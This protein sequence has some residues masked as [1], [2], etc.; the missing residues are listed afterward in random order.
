MT[1]IKCVS[2][3]NLSVKKLK[4]NELY[5]EA[6]KCKLGNGKNRTAYVCYLLKHVK[7]IEF[8]CV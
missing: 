8:T 4:Y 2:Y 5:H 7:I 6:V 3:W 1:S